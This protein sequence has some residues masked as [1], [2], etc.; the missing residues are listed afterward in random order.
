MRFFYKNKL[1]IKKFVLF[2]YCLKTIIM[3]NIFLRF[4][5]YIVIFSLI[6]IFSG[7]S[8]SENP[9]TTQNPTQTENKVQTF[10]TDNGG[11][12]SVPS[13]YEMTIAS[14]TVPRKQSG[15]AGSVSFT[16]EAGITPPKQIPAGYTLIGSYVKFGPDGF[17]F[18]NP[19]KCT[20]PAAS[21]E[22]P[23]N[24]VVLYFFP[25]QEEWRRVTTST[26]DNNRK[27]ISIDALKLG[28]YALVKT[29]DNLD[30]PSTSIGGIQYGSSSNT[31]D[32]FTI[33]VRSAS[34]EYP[35]QEQW[36]YG[37]LAGYTFSSVVSS[38]GTGAVNPVYAYLPQGMYTLWISKRTFQ[39]TGTGP[40]YTNSS[41]VT[42]TINNALTYSGWGNITGWTTVPE[43]SGNWVQ[44]YPQNW[45]TPTI[46]YGTGLFQATLVWLNSSSSNATDL[47]LHLLGPDSLHIYWGNPIGPDTTFFLDV[48]W[49][50]QLGYACENIYC[51]KTYIPSG[52]YS[53]WIT[54]YEGY[55]P[56]YFIIRIILFPYVYSYYGWISSGGALFVQ[57]FNVP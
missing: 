4:S 33:T 26:V 5:I 49:R 20:F 41:Y 23:A 14:G 16:I 13:G 10:T 2:V 30:N 52:Y 18:A 44:G 47:D 27:T 54:H 46:P 7:C 53:V 37:G 40:I 9:V 15:E 51:T 24:L 25:E 32:L 19:V 29:P 55:S 50:L 3:N 56:K 38:S 31:Q 28:Y 34:L 42:V 8:K 36:Y 48:D 57:Q 39:G 43:P 12:L 17:N 45:S 22:S 21:Q 35:Y 1:H 6:I 11:T